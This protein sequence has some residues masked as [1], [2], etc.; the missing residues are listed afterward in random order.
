MTDGSNWK[1]GKWAL[2][3]GLLAVLVYLN[4]LR[5][6]LIYDGQFLVEGNGTFKDAAAK[7]SIVSQIAGLNQVFHEGFWDG[8]NKTL[9]PARKIYGQALYR[10]LMLWTMGVLSLLFDKA[11]IAFNLVNLLFHVLASIALLRLAWLLTAN[12]AIAVIA[13]L[14]FAVHP[15]HA[16]AV[17]YAAGI[18][19]TQSTLFALCA[20]LL[21]AGATRSGF[22]PLQYALSLL[23]F[24]IALFTKESAALVLVFAILFDVARRDVA[25]RPAWNV[26]LLAYLGFAAVI[27]LNIWVRI[28][29][30]G[31]LAPDSALINRLDNPLIHSDFMTRLA[32][33]VTL[34]ARVLRLFVFPYPQSSDYSFNQL[35]I[36]GSLLEPASLT[37]FLLLALMTIGGLLTLRK[38]PALGFGMLAFLFAFG[39]AS[40]IPVGI[41]TIFGE[42]LAYLPT[43]GLALAAAALLDALLRF[44]AARGD[45]AL[46]AARTVLVALLVV[47]AVVSAIRN[48]AYASHDALYADMMKHAPDSAR[49]FYQ[50]AEL[51]RKK[52]AD[53]T[54]GDLAVAI[55]NYKNA[56]AIMDDFFMA[57]MQL[58]VAYDQNGQY[59][60]A[61]ETLQELKQ[62]MPVNPRTKPVIG[63]LEQIITRV[64]A[65]ARGSASTTA[66]SAEYLAKLITQLEELHT[67]HPD[68]NGLAVDL[69][70]LYLQAE[71]IDEAMRVLQ[72]ALLAAPESETLK[73]LL[74]QIYAGRSETEKVNA[75]IDELVNA[76]DESARKV[77]VMYAAI[78]ENTEASNAA[79]PDEQRDGFDKALKLFERYNTEFGDRADAWCLQA[80]IKMEVK[81]LFEEAFNDLK[82][83][84]SLDKTYSPA[85]LAIARCLVAMRRF[86][87]S[88][89]KIFEAIEAEAKATNSE[90]PEFYIGFGRVLMEFGLFD[91]AAEKFQR[92]IDLGLN[93]PVPY[94]LLAA[95]WTRAG[96]PELALKSL[97][98][99]ED[100]GIKNADL[101][102]G[103]G[104]ALYDLKQYEKAR[105]EFNRA[106][107]IQWS[108]D[109]DFQ[110]AK[111]DLRIV[112][113]ETQGYAELQRL[114]AS[115]ENAAQHAT[116]EQERL[117]HA[118]L[119]PY[120]RRQLAWAHSNVA[121]LR[122]DKK[123]VELLEEACQL[124]E[125]L[126][127]K[128]ELKDDLRPDLIAA[129]RAAGDETKAQE[130][131]KRL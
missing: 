17:A 73:G 65:H 35:P 109:L 50:Y 28:E 56:I 44:M 119:R 69:C 8:V 11:A 113:H 3:V 23:C 19:E 68:D 106:R 79:T 92:A 108:A 46:R 104:A 14:L 91:R 30:L 47:F 48:N 60:E 110:V 5:H 54:G 80:L 81:G 101:V 120:V 52:K 15:L 86:D 89:L 83:S 105:F 61:I 24:A 33:G 7:G 38:A 88:T 76:K 16:E 21:Y 75:L 41:G 95:A 98:E 36:A 70:N 13:A 71:R 111:C 53:K 99:A 20:L 96:K 129:Y 103:Q 39:P 12:R 77:G 115:L 121:N 66:E 78:R 18:G 27:G 26:R 126:G 114:D 37:S 9:D 10:P 57:R 4:A 43:V 128:A 34:Y 94:S 72:P 32:T 42:R 22:R 124:A 131:E 112:G 62:R 127:M 6:E 59:Q 85:Y 102:Q 100:K 123:A 125:S 107:E 93:G 58:G 74:V 82:K 31:T 49:G 63:Q 64:Y 117:G 122:D 2:L 87:A 55:E 51:Q 118:A 67:E 90:T 97:R 25:A 130:L 116:N 45:V 40:N 1:L 29:V 84:L